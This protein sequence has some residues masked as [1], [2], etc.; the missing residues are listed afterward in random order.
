M[1]LQRRAGIGLPVMKPN[2]YKTEP[3]CP[4]EKIKHCLQPGKTGSV[5]HPSP[6]EDLLGRYQN[7]KAFS[8][9]TRIGPKWS[10]CSFFP[11]DP[12]FQKY[13]FHWYY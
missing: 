3:C 7:T 9:S 5:D 10:S 1:T 8:W 11:I 13:R 4:K 6:G 12:R 2:T